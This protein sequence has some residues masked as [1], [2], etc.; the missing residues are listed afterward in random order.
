MT[1]NQYWALDKLERK[2]SRREELSLTIGALLAADKTGNLSV[3]RIRELYN[4]L[5]RDKDKKQFVAYVKK[6]LV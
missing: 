4:G 2:H 5:S 1:N 6:V 3:D